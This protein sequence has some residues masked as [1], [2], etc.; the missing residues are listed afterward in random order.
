MLKYLNYLLDVAG[1]NYIG[2][3]FYEKEL[4]D[5]INI[6]KSSFGKL[7]EDRIKLEKFILNIYNRDGDMYH[8]TLFSVPEYNKIKHL[9]SKEIFKIV[10]D[11][12][13]L[14]IGKAIKNSNETNFIVV[15]SDIL[16]KIR[17]DL[18]F[19]LKDLHITLGFDKKDV[20]GVDKGENSIYLE[21]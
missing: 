18:G 4:N 6:W 21:F 19:E 11:I 16:N 2:V 15:K 8:I 12:Q 3:K 9:D 7:E 10:D 1:N 17:T 20:F 14:G 5:Y 13:F